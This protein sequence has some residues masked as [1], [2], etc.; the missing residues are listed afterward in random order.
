VVPVA[1][2]DPIFSSPAFLKLN[3]HTNPA[4]QDLC[5]RKVP[6]D[7]IKPQLLEKEGKLVEALSAG[8]WSG[9][10]YEPQ[11]AFLAKKYGNDPTTA[12]Q[13]WTREEIKSSSYDVGTQLTN[14]FEVLTKS[15]ESIVFRCGDSPL[16]QEIRPVDGLFEIAATINRDEGVVEFG[17]KS[18]FFQGLG[19]ADNKPVPRLIELAHRYYTKLLMETAV[20][21]VVL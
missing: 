7:K 6:I 20:Q 8:V 15:P 14:H 10:G 2:A 12:H 17:L 3:P 19:K 16:K 1:P 18:V 13:L 9:L 11:R 21:N 5:V 4:M